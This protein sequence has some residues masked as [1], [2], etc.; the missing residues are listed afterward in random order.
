MKQRSG[1]G[2]KL[3][4]LTKISWAKVRVKYLPQNEDNPGYFFRLCDYYIN[5]QSDNQGICYLLFAI[6]KMDDKI[7]GD[8]YG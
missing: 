3:N 6:R 8:D 2:S 5:Q 4:V 1:T 7:M